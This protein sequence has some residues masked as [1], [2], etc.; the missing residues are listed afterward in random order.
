MTKKTTYKII[1]AASLI[2]FGAIGRILLQDLPNI[3]TI[4]VISLLAGSLLG[5][6][7]A[8]AIPLI[9]IAITDIIIGN[10]TIMLFTWSA[11]AVIGIFGWLLRNKKNFSP[12]FIF[13]MTGMG[14]GAALFFYVYT[15]FGVWLLFPMYPHTLQGLAACY[16][17]GI[18]FLKFSLAGNLIIVPAA[19]IGFTYLWKRFLYPETKKQLAEK[20]A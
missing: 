4:T 6:R 12:K 19:S 5:F 2:A 15:N 1:L 17:A 7:F 18:P 3:E 20:K 9:T 11:F 10:N 8:I 14:V 13:Q 16:I